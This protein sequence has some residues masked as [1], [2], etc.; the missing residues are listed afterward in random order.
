M[1]NKTYTSICNYIPIWTLANETECNSS[2]LK[3]MS[4]NDTSGLYFNNTINTCTYTAPS[5]D[6]GGGSGG[7][8]SSHECDYEGTIHTSESR[9]CK[10]SH[11]HE[12]CWK[13]SA[14]TDS[15]TSQ[16]K[17]ESAEITI[18]PINKEPVVTE[19]IQPVTQE[20]KKDYTTWWI[21]GIFLAVII[22]IAGIWYFLIYKKNE[23]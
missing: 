18:E 13:S 9:F 17:P 12:T 2:G 11:N 1:P 3:L 5:V 16:P 23:R 7:G 15:S 19:S 21:A 22:V 8:G 14:S 10:C 4:Y 20:P 6:N